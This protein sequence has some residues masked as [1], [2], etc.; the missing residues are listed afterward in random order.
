M[1]SE[2][3]R[4]PDKELYLKTELSEYPD[5]GCELYPS[6][7]NCPLPDCVYDLPRGISQVKLEQRNEQILQKAEEGVPTKEIS[8][9]FKVSVRTIQRILHEHNNNGNDSKG[10]GDV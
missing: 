5:N 3:N 1:P 2:E 9:L 10:G 4:F 6:C 8:R 7:L